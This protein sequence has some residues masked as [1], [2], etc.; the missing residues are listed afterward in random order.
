[1]ATELVPLNLM[2][3]PA[4]RAQLLELQRRLQDRLSRSK[5]LGVSTTR[6]T[7]RAAFVEA[8]AALQARLDDLERTNR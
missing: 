4:E 3:S 5:T 2:V 7:Q 6:V 1:M 8:L